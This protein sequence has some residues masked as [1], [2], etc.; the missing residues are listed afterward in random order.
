MM[1]DEGECLQDTGMMLS[2]G[3][4]DTSGKTLSKKE[5]KAFK[6]KLKEKRKVFIDSHPE[7]STAKKSHLDL[8]MLVEELLNK[9]SV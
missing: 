2:W 5:S 8:Y 7:W 9:K 3:D 1:I 6:K 4:S